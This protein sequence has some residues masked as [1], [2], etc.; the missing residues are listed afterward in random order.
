VDRF[1]QLS[2]CFAAVSLAAVPVASAHHHD[3]GEHK[4]AKKHAEAALR[5]WRVLTQL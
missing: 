1:F 2:R 4:D 3:L 5:T